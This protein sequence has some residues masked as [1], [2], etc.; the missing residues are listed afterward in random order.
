MQLDNFLPKQV[1]DMIDNLNMLPSIGR[2][3]AQRLAFYILKQD[4]D[5]ARELAENILAGRL[6]TQFCESCFNL[7]SENVCRVCLSKKRNKAKICVVESVLDLIAIERSGVFDGVY[8]VL[9]GV[10]SPLDGVTPKQL[11]I[12]ELC[13]RVTQISN[14]FDEV[15]VVLATPTTAEGDATNIYISEMLKNAPVSIS[16]LA[17]GLPHGGI[18]DYADE[19][20]LQN[21][22][23]DRKN[24]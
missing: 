4:E 11:H 23:S 3:S 5:F 10:L 15:E 18:L 17:S 9:H 6:D 8:H 1:C 22:F 13:K 7:S 20:T 14:E 16:K 19:V 2:R 12:D 24:Y 21:A